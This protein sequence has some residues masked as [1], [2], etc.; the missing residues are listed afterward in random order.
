MAHILLVDDDEAFTAATADLLTMLGHTLVTAHSVEQAM[1]AANSSTFTHVILD[2]ILPDGSGLHVLDSLRNVSSDLKI[3]LVTGHDSIKSIIKN[4]YGPNIRYFLKPIDLETLK[5]FLAEEED[6]QKTELS[7]NSK[8]HFGHLIGESVQMQHL[9][10]MIERVSQT[11]ANVLLVGESGSGKEEVASA[12]HFA[13][14][15]R[16]DFVPVNCGALSPELINSELFGHEKGA[17]TGAVARKPGVFELADNGTLFLDEITEM[18]LDLQP[19]LLRVLETSRVTRLG[20]TQSLSFTCRVV[21]ATNRGEADIVEQ[22]RL[23]EDLYFRLAVFPIHIPPLRAR[24]PDIPLLVE[25][26]LQ[27]LNKQYSSNIGITEHDLHRLSQYD[28][29]G[30][31]RELKH[32][33]HRAFIMADQERSLIRLPEQIESPFS[34]QGDHRRNGIEFGKT[35]EDVERELIETTLTHLDGD[36]KQAAEML[37]ISLKTLY[38]RLNKYESLQE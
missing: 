14:A 10:E 3:A 33:L 17:F 32:C 38:N 31:V 18:P 35:V 30:N 15:P 12:I 23:R 34:R 6:N 29:P 27:Q 24:K 25:F 28:W 26:F 37:G 36:K 21:S 4:F 20:A 22:Q 5:A 1:L 2:L 7:A 9:Y 13:T 19:N 11:R 8:A 16:G